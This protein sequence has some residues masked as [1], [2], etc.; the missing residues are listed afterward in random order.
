MAYMPSPWQKSMHARAEPRKWIWV[1]RRGGKGRAVLHEALSVINTASFSPF[2][3]DG[4]DM[5]DS[6]TPQ[7]HVWCVAPNYGQAQQVWNEMKA[8][9]PAHMVKPPQNLRGNRSSTGWNEASMNVWLDLPLIDGA[10]NTRSRTQVFWEIKSAD[11]F[12]ML[13]TVGLDFLWMTESQDIKQGAW[14]KVRPILSSPGRLGR[15]C[16]E[17]IPPLNRAHWFSRGYNDAIRRP[18]TMDTAIT[19]TTFDNIYLTEDQKD[20]IRNEKR[21]TTEA[22]WNRMYM[23][24]QPDSGGAFFSASAIDAA[25]ISN[26]LT[27]PEP[28][29]KYIAG[30]DLGK[31]TDPTVLIIKDRE[32]RESVF[33]IEMLH[34]DWGVQ[35]ST[36]AFETERWGCERIMMDSTGMGGD[37]LFDEFL[38]MG[39]PVEAFKFTNPSKHQ[40]FLEL[41]VALEQRTTSFP[42][43]WENLIE[44]MEGFEVTS[45][46]TMFRYRQVNT[47]HDDWRYAE[48]LAL[49]A[50]D[51]AREVQEAR[52]R[53]H[54]KAG[55]VGINGNKKKQSAM[56]RQV[57]DWR[58]DSVLN[59]RQPPPDIVINGDPVVMG[60]SIEEY[61]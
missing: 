23:A 41:A 40:L 48:A 3:H 26:E 32:T 17:G 2:I 56:M 1:G 9:I 22:M 36:I 44:Q 38:D 24:I 10:G 20:D 16:I 55:A 15:A 57:S 5:T 6:L 50:C 58:Q 11:N 39:L 49:R 37:V 25:K 7:I 52:L 42:A 53:V 18:T 12:E 43:S 34:R 47:G 8:F 33:A 61:R 51:P 4:L 13:Q 46:C 31:Q 54:G 29:H 35:K 19:A 27:Y 28:A 21:K 14:D 59:E 45:Q 30:L 60:Q